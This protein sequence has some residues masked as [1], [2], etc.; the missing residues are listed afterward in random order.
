[1]VPFDIIF[2]QHLKN[3]S[4]YRVVVLADQECLG[5][6]QMEQIRKFVERGGGLVATEQTSLYTGRRLRRADFG[7]KDLFGVSAPRWEGPTKQ[8]KDL[9]TN[10]VQRRVG[11]GRVTYIP[12]VKPAIEK[13]PAAQMSSRYWKLPVNWKELVE[14]V[15][16]AAAGRLSLEVNSPGTMAVVAEL[17]EQPARSRRLVHLVN[18]AGPQGKLVTNVDVAVELPSGKRVRQVTLISPDTPESHNVPVRME[19]GRVH[20]TVPRLDT[21]SI[22]ILEM[23]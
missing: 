2:D 10:P 3:L 22:G 21:Y 4:K 15:R 9:Q 13:P 5:D 11:K 6:Q 7:L 14:G 23:E 17:M 19:E 12:S 16:W 8:E 20:F 18:Y 1:M